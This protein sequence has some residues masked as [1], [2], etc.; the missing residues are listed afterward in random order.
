MRKLDRDE[1]PGDLCAATADMLR[2]RTENR[3]LELRLEATRK[4]NAQSTAQAHR[5]VGATW[6]MP[7]SPRR[8]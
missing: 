2:R 3:K 8:S 7:A 5:I 1:T 4:A 6:E